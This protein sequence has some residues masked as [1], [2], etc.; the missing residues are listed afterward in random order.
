[1]RTAGSLDKEATSYN[2]CFDAF[3]LFDFLALGYLGDCQHPD[4][5]HQYAEKRKRCVEV[6]Q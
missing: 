5:K 6:L 3:R 2:D 1:L 4:K